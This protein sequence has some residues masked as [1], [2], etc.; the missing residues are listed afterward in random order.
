MPLWEDAQQHTGACD[1]FSDRPGSV[2]RRAPAGFSA[3]EKCSVARKQ[4]LIERA[5]LIMDDA[6]EQPE[7]LDRD[8]PLPFQPHS[9]DKLEVKDCTG[10]DGPW[11]AYAWVDKASK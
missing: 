6:T 10:R 7:K 2:S 1:D 5:A 4:K 9:W 3:A 11:F 8:M